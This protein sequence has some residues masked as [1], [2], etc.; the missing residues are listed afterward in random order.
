MCPSKLQPTVRQRITNGILNKVMI[1]IYKS[2]QNDYYIYVPNI[3][4]SSFVDNHILPCPVGT[5]LKLH[6]YASDRFAD[7]EFLRT[8][9]GFL[10]P[11]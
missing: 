5:R 8:E 4:Y 10:Y 2:S 11:G 1:E 9:A 3:T 6:T 7:V